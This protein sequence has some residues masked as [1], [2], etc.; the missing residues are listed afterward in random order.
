[1]TVEAK[2]AEVM[3][4]YEIVLNVGKSKNVERGFLVTVW[5][6]VEVNDPDTGKAIGL[7]RRPKLRFQVTEV[8]DSLCIAESIEFAASALDTL[9]SSSGPE[10]KRVARV[11]S[12]RVSSDET[13]VAIG[14]A[15]TLQAPPPPSSPAKVKSA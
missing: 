6:S 2:V 4:P 8:Q 1:L 9:L 12:A 13:P 15:A 7:V 14:D 5:R 11:G 3:P 10:R